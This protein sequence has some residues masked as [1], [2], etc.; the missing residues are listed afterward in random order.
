MLREGV[1]KPSKQ[2]CTLSKSD[3]FP[4]ML[5]LCP[6]M[7]LRKSAHSD[8]EPELEENAPYV[9][10]PQ[11]SIGDAIAQALEQ[12][13]SLEPTTGNNETSNNSH[14]SGKKKGKKLKG[15][16]ISL[17]AAARPNI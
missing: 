17:F 12:A 16:K 6:T 11:Q 14:A 5:S 15:K 9:A 3:T 4:G 7:R 1:A 2:I 8:S 13:C 10:P